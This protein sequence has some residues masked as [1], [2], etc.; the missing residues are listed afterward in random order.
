MM[1]FSYFLN[2]LINTD[3]KCEYGGINWESV[4]SKYERIQEIFIDS[5]PKNSVE[6]QGFP[7]LE[8]PEVISKDPVAG[9]LKKIRQDYKKAADAKRKSGGCCA[10]FVFY[11]LCKT[12]WGESL[13]VT[14]LQEGIDSSS[15][16][17]QEN[18]DC[19]LNGQYDQLDSGSSSSNSFPS[20]SNVTDDLDD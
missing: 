9:K 4:C 10:V 14:S 20:L 12:I 17:D 16:V 2:Q 8:N 3:V 6:G 1:R 11:D 19:V 13:A 5:Y 18:V 7:V 15:Q